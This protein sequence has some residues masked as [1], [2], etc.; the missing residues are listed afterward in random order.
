MRQRTREDVVKA[1]MKARG[2]K[3]TVEERETDN[4]HCGGQKKWRRLSR[5]RQEARKEGME[6][7]EDDGGG[8]G[9]KVWTIVEM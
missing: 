9:G 3:K 4:G 6:E 8:G 2:I 5:G 7:R 1:L